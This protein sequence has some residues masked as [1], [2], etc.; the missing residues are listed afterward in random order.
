MNL[1]QFYSL[2]KGTEEAPLSCDHILQDFSTSISSPNFPLNYDNNVNC[3][4]NITVFDGC[5]VEL[6]FTRFDLQ[7]GRDNLTVYDG[8]DRNS[9]RNEFTGSRLPPPIRSTTNHLF[10]E[11]STDSTIQRSGFLA[12]Y[13]TGEF[14]AKCHFKVS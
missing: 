9:S 1:R 11:L 7:F 4:W 8:Y 2:N 12:T 13:T 3:S 10:L 6:N 5:M 14:L